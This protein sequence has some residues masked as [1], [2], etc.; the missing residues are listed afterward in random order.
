MQAN[1]IMNADMLD[2]LFEHKNKAYGAYNLRRTYDKR[3]YAALG[4]TFAV[5]LLFTISTL[6][7][8]EGNKK[9]VMEVSDYVLLNPLE[10]VKKKEQPIPE[11]AA[12]APPAAAPQVIQQIRVTNVTPPRIVRDDQVTADNTV[13]PVEDLDKTIIGNVTLAG[14]DDPG[15]IAPPVNPTGTGGTGG[16]RIGGGGNEVVDG[17]GFVTVQV[18]ARFPGGA[19]AWKKYLER[20]LNRD[21]PIENGASIGRYTVIVSFVVDKEGNLSDVKAENNPGWGTA[22]EAVRVI[23][24]GP[25]WQPAI[26]NGRNVTYRQRQSITFEVNNEG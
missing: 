24:R 23:K 15:S 14:S 8:G 20:N 2:I 9:T 21:L 12:P 25:K 13:P 7:A 16:G 17:G 1:N 10:E 19:E 4:A 3:L 18:E 11:V 22:D 26:Q 6:F 5:G